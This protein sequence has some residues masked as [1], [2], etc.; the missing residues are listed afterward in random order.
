M[1][2]HTSRRQSRSA[3]SVAAVGAAV[4]DLLLPSSCAACGKLGVAVC[5]AC[6][7]VLE[8]GPVPVRPGVATLARH[9]GAA[10][11]LV[12]AHKAQGRRELAVPLG[13]ALGRAVPALAEAEP[14]HNGTLWLVPVPSR[15]SAARVRGGPHVAALARWCAAELAERGESVAVAPALRLS[16]RARDAVG[17][18]RAERVANL[19]GRVGV[20]PAGVPAPGT[21]V[22]LLDDVV[23]TGATLDACARALSRAGV[24][25][26]AAL[27]LT[28][29]P[30]PRRS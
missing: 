26:R 27:T 20:V 17:L 3:G 15:P 22:V 11:Q 4:L 28:A 23:T 10:R 13:R 2:T 9:D 14:D 12:L 21:P 30:A 19:S 1:R 29:A 24:R 25:V 16:S 8:R 5:R 7:A 6:L 18:S